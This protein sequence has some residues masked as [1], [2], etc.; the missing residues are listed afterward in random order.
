MLQAFG[1]E[2][3]RTGDEGGDSKVFWISRTEPF[4]GRILWH[5]GRIG[6]EARDVTLLG[7]ASIQACVKRGLFRPGRLRSPDGRATEQRIMVATEKMHPT[8]VHAFPAFG[9]R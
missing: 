4:T 7:D 8:F 6:G 5:L 9:E 2:A 3:D 1:Y